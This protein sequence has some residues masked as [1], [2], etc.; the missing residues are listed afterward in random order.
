MYVAMMTL[1]R[2]MMSAQ[3]T[4]STVFSSL[5]YSIYEGMK[6]LVQAMK[7]MRCI[8]ISF[9]LTATPPIKE[10]CLRMKR[11]P[12]IRSTPSATS[13][14]IIVQKETSKSELYIMIKEKI[15]NNSDANMFI[16]LKLRLTRRSSLFFGLS[17]FSARLSACFFS[18]LNVCMIKPVSK[19]YIG[20]NQ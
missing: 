9:S 14:E 12:I 13:I 16:I 1:N 2:S 19:N 6:K 7:L 15:A 5:M 3:N 10:S 8:R 4:C 17:P 18:F 20:K 11:T